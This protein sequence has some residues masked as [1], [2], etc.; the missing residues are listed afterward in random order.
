MAHRGSPARRV[1]G[2]PLAGVL[3]EVGRRART[4]ARRSRTGREQDPDPREVTALVRPA[5]APSAA[6]VRTDDTGRARWVFPMPYIAPPVLTAL[7]VDPDPGGD[8]TVTAAL[9][10]VGTWYAVV[11]VW[12]TRRGQGVVE[13]AGEGVLV[14]ITAVAAG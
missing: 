11:R 6:V 7:P 14:H 3:G 2:N 13:P 8:C 12:R 9:E 4:T 10:E 1:V 5:A